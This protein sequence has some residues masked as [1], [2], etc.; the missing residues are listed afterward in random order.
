ML[1]HA[2]PASARYSRYVRVVIVGFTR[3]F[4]ALVSLLMW[5]VSSEQLRADHQ[6]SLAAEQ[7]YVGGIISL[8]VW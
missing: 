2:Y 6:Q 1:I 4:Y 3:W 5:T 7:M 8:T